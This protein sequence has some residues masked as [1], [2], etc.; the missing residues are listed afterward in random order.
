MATIGGLFS[1]WKKQKSKTGLWGVGQYGCTFLKFC[2]EQQYDIDAVIDCNEGKHGNIISGYPAVCF[3][4]E[5]C[6]K[7]QIVI[8]TSSN[9]VSVY[10]LL[11]MVKILF[12]YPVE[13]QSLLYLKNDKSLLQHLSLLCFLML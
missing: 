11:I 13:D 4:E 5:I 1:L 2:R 8:L 9:L 3:P 6:D 7:L 12:Q 10:I